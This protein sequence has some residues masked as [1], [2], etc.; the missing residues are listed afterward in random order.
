[1]FTVAYLQHDNL[2]EATRFLVN[3]LFK[4]YGLVIVDG[5]DKKLKE[6]FIPYVKNEIIHQQS[7]EKINATSELLKDY[8]IQVMP[9]EINLFYIENDLRERIVFE[10]NLYKVLHTQL[11]FT[12][13]EILQEI[14]NYPEKFSP[15]VVLRPLYQ[16]VILPN[17]CYI[18]GGGEL[19]YWL[20]LKSNFEEN[21]I[22]FPMLLLRNSVIVA[23]EKQ[24]NKREKLA[25]T[26]LDLFA[27][28]SELISRKT[29]EFSE[30]SLDFSSQKNFLQQQFK[31]LYKIASQ[32]DASYFGAVAAQEKKQLKGLENLEQKLIKAE[33]KK[34]ADQ[35]A[36]IA[37]L[38][39][40][41]FPN[42]GL[43]ERKLNFSEVAL[44]TNISDF[45]A[46]LYHDFDP[47]AQHF[48]IE[49][50]K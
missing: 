31:E 39:N 6:L 26:W 15:N 41:L 25:L 40:E 19:A 30:L 16:E 27:K 32:T 24:N 38:Q 34:Y 21:S 36:R 22:P 1:L 8:S 43:Q 45:I 49:I 48:T 2:A 35:L 20:Q 28:Q 33:K 42:G 4:N 17:L 7:F 47:L 29:A 10:N 9:R 13:A 5:D 23:T 12:E 3:E 50:L 44:E 18:G 11:Q 46:Q 14:E 37:S